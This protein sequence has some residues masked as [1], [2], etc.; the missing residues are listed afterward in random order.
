MYPYKGIRK[1]KH[2]YEGN[3]DNEIEQLEPYQGE[4]LELWEPVQQALH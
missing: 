3:S 2:E 1:P 4:P